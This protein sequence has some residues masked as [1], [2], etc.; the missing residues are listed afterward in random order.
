MSNEQWR[1][2]R[3]GAQGCQIKYKTSMQY[4]GHTKKSYIIYLNGINLYCHV[5]FTDERFGVLGD[6]EPVG[7]LGHTFML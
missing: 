5:R 6:W 4:L 2:A 3:L 7:I 1:R